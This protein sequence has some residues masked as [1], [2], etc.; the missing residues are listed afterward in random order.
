MGFGE[1]KIRIS[2]AT[3]SW[4]AQTKHKRNES[5]SSAA[6]GPAALLT[7]LIVG[8]TDAAVVGPRHL[9]DI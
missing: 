4:S 9:S 7:C 2:S 3:A 6:D 5:E 1:F 8:Y